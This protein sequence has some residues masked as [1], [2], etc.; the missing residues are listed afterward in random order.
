MKSYLQMKHTQAHFEGH[1]F[2]SEH[3]PTTYIL[4]QTVTDPV[5]I[6]VTGLATQV[7]FA[8]I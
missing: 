2:H 7:Y 6:L 4:F 1:K 5:L 3:F 8:V